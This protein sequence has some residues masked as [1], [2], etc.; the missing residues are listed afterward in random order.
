MG[1]DEDPVRIGQLV[2]DKKFGIMNGED[3]EDEDDVPRVSS[4]TRP[5]LEGKYEN[6]AVGRC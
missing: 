2:G 6:A 5:I 1:P 4:K 3:E